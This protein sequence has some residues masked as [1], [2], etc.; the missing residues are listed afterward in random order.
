MDGSFKGIM[1]T[2]T[3]KVNS[4][5]NPYEDP[6]RATTEDSE[7][8]EETTTIDV[9]SWGARPVETIWDKSDRAK[10][11]RKAAIPYLKTSLR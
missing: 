6:S 4:R 2:E 7:V 3:R 8:S 9:F 11:P 1:A 10:T 5:G